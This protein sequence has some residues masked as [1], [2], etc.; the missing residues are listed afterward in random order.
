M[1]IAS[2]VSSLLGWICGIGPILGVV[3][4]IIAL[5]QIKQTGQGGHGLALAGLIIGGIGLAIMASYLIFAIIYG[6][7]HAGDASAAAELITL[8]RQAISP[9]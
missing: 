7:A 5:K 6:A 4:G 8:G 2:L 1:A 3:F 9:V